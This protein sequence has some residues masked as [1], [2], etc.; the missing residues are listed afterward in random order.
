VTEVIS[1]LVTT[2]L[3]LFG[4]VELFEWSGSAPLIGGSIVFVG[5][6][7][8]F[9]R[10]LERYLVKPLAFRHF[11]MTDNRHCFILEARI[12]A[13]ID[14]RGTAV[15]ETWRDYL[16]T[17][18]PQPWNLF[19]TLYA[20]PGFA[21]GETSYGWLYHSND[22][23]V[24]GFKRKG[25]D[26]LVVFWQPRPQGPGIHK[27]RPYRHHFRWTVPGN[28]AQTV[29]FH[30][31]FRLYDT[32][33]YAARF[34][35]SHPIVDVWAVRRPKDL[36]AAKPEDWFRQLKASP[37]AEGVPQPRLTDMYTFEW[38][39]DDPLPAVSYVLIWDH[40]CTAA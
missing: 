8:V 10:Q 13:S 36:T 30:Q 12:E 37:L 19:D 32:G 40:G 28:L 1:R 39:I 14:P 25:K 26:R 31:V 15:A 29:N 27:L 22:A 16:F 23:V 7:L 18:P 35:T 11:G 6:V 21:P 38:Q 17:A 3:A 5:L 20:V 9:A 33:R 24:T 34:H 4:L 2:V